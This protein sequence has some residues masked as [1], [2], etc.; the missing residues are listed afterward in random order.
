MEEDETVK[1]EAP[2]GGDAVVVA[3]VWWKRNWLDYPKRTSDEEWGWR[4]ILVFGLVLVAGGSGAL[5]YGWSSGIAAVLF[6]SW[7]VL[8]PIILKAWHTYWPPSKRW[9]EKY[10]DFEDKYAAKD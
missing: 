2:E 10:I 6:G 7:L 8:R 3:A 4:A 5:V 1:D 9:L